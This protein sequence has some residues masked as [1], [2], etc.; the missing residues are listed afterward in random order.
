M[1]N[2]DIYTIF[3]ILLPKNSIVGA[4]FKLNDTHLDI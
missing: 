1:L 4:F 3:H 2:L